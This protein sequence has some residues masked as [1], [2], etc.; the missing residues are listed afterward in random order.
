M[1]KPVEA[2]LFAMLVGLFVVAIA[3]SLS[4]EPA[5]EKTRT[6]D[7]AHFDS[8]G[9]TA[10]LFYANLEP[11]SVTQ[12]ETLLPA[13]HSRNR[14]GEDAVEVIVSVWKDGGKLREDTVW[15]RP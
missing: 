9:D 6:P 8:V 3:A 2:F 14:W 15:R 13:I 10:R 5:I 1:M 4:Y 12:L 7:G 11:D